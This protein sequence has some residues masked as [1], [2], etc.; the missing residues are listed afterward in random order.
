M[1]ASKS[2]ASKYIKRKLTGLKGKKDKSKNTAGDFQTPLSATGR[3]MTIQKIWKDAEDFNNIIK[4][5]D[6]LNTQ[7]T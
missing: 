6:L 2:R 4:H 7:V 1:N 3:A 5:L